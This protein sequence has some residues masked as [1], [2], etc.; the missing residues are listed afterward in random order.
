M[1]FFSNSFIKFDLHVTSLCWITS[2][3]DALELLQ[4][5]TKPSTSTLSRHIHSMPM[6]CCIGSMWSTCLE[7]VSAKNFEML[8]IYSKSRWSTRDIQTFVKNESTGQIKPGEWNG[9]PSRCRQKYL[10]PNWIFVFQI[11]WSVLEVLVPQMTPRKEILSYFNQDEHNAHD[12]R[13]W[14]EIDHI[15][16]IVIC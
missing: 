7:K 12:T 5:C 13:Q 4:S 3:D 1:H 11:N 6:A 16:H 8:R 14:S 9:I 10:I 2:M 15:D